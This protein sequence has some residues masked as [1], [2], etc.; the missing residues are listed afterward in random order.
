MLVLM[1]G[2]TLVITLKIFICEGRNEERNL[3]ST[4]GIDLKTLFSR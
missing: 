2:W 4:N 3:S 1:L